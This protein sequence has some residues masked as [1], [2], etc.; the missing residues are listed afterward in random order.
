MLTT[1]RS[2][3]SD[4]HLITGSFSVRFTTSLIFLSSPL[5]L[6]LPVRLADSPLIYHANSSSLL[7]VWVFPLGRVASGLV[8]P[9]LLPVSLYA[10]FFSLSTL[11]SLAYILDLYR[12]SSQLLLIGHNAAHR[13]AL[14]LSSRLYSFV[15]DVFSFCDALSDFFPFHSVVNSYTQPPPSIHLVDFRS[16]FLTTRSLSDSLS[17][18][19]DPS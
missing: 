18:H 2:Y 4:Q 7:S 5:L 6:F 1:P 12:Q 3:L 16:T 14:V 19:E 10:P 13:K 11:H 15:L 8:Q 17:L 9:S